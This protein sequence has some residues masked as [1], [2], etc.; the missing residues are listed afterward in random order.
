MRAVLD[1]HALLWWHQDTLDRLSMRQ[2]QVLKQIDEEGE[3]VISVISLWEIA[4][5]VSKGHLKPDGPLDLWLAKLENQAR[6]RVEPLSARIITTSA[7]LPSF[8]RDPADEIITATAYCLGL[9]LVTSDDRIRRWA[10]S[11]L[12]KVI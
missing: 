2:K 3:F 10:G 8:H 12:V 6:L 7:T 5:L 9:P 1:T 4:K 11:G